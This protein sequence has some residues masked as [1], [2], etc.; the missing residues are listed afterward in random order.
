MVFCRE[1]TL[2]QDRQEKVLALLEQHGLALHRLL[3]RLTRCEHTTGDLMQ[4]LFLR[5]VGSRGFEK[6]R[7]PY[8]FAW[9]TATNLAF[10]WRRRRRATVTLPAE[11]AI[12]DESPTPLGH[13]LEA[14]RLE[15]VLDATAGLGQLARHVVIMRFIEQA[16]YDE[17]AK[18]L[19]KNPN[20]I[21][22]LCSKSIRKLRQILDHRDIAAV[23]TEVNH[24]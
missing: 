9:R 20:H 19:G 14:E 16:S 24:D 2:L 8:A 17:I 11:P 4:E 21:R 12:P 15:R 5:L 10:Q 13:V 3:A 6:A 18:R 7:S 23:R 22:V 1:R